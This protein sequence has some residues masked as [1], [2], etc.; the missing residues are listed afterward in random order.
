VN[1]E[2]ALKSAGIIVPVPLHRRRQKE[3]GFN[4]VDLFA[5]PLA[6]LLN[7]PLSRGHVGS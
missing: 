7:I 1:L 3:R 5:R 4:Q 6:K 2:P